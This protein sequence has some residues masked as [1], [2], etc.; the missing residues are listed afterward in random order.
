MVLE[1]PFACVAA[2]VANADA[3]AVVSVAPIAS[4]VSLALCAKCYIIITS[5][6]ALVDA[7]CSDVALFAAALTP[8]FCLLIL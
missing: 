7:A 8:A 3:S 4:V 1:S 5:N 6:V 2:V